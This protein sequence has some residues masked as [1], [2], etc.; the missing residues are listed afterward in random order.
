LKFGVNNKAKTKTDGEKLIREDFSRQI[1]EFE[2]VLEKLAKE[3]TEVVLLERL[4]PM[5]LWAKCEACVTRLKDLAQ[6]SRDSMLTLKPEKAFTI[7]QHCKAFVQALT[8]FKDILFQKSADPLAN[9]RL[10]F[11]QLR[12][13]LNKGSDFLVLMKE[14]RQKPSSVIDAVL[15]LREAVESKAKV[16]TIQTTKDVQPMLERLANCIA[17]LRDSIVV[18]DRALSEV[19]ERLHVLEEESIKFGFE[20]TTNI[21]KSSNQAVVEKGDKL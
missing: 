3:I 11:E 21:R 17:A 20:E 6:N 19:K 18:L 8:N 2:E 14:I 7:E 5:D 13:A 12:E 1:S 9:S 16:V 4:P 10:A 15:K